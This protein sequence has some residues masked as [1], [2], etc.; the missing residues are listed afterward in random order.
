MAR[1]LLACSLLVQLAASLTPPCRVGTAALQPSGG[2]GICYCSADQVAFCR[3]DPW[4]EVPG[5]KCTGSLIF[6]QS[7]KQNDRAGACGY[8]CVCGA[9][10][11]TCCLPGD[12]MALVGGVVVRR[13]HGG[14]RSRAGGR[15]R[16]GDWMRLLLLLPLVRH[17]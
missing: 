1:G 6:A 10:K 4:E 2:S 12:T 14:G 3:P 11:I 17:A 5:D 8:Y 16:P 9:K 7:Q 13:G 15:P